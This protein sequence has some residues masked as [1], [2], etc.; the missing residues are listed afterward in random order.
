MNGHQLAALHHNPSAPSRPDAAPGRV[1][2]AGR[3][4]AEGHGVMVTTPRQLAC[5]QHDPLGPRRASAD[6]VVP[7]GRE[8]LI[9]PVTTRSLTA[10]WLDPDGA[11]RPDAKPSEAQSLAC[12]PNRA[13][14]GNQVSLRMTERPGL[15][16]ASNASRES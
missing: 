5:L 13:Q 7:A 14:S 9:P 3:P 15:Q 12:S 8:A 16:A 6:S 11:R 10:L 2:S 1:P 4:Q